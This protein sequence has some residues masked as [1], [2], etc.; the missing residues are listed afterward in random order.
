[1]LVTLD[2]EVPER[3]YV[4]KNRAALFKKWLIKGS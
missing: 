4:S 2:V 1:L 3:L